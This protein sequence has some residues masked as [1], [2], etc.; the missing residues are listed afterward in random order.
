MLLIYLL[1]KFDAKKINLNILFNSAGKAQNFCIV[2][3]HWKEI[4]NDFLCCCA[5]G[6]RLAQVMDMTTT[7]AEAQEHNSSGSSR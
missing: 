2:L 1:F 6:K 3:L 5:I 7:N 4:E